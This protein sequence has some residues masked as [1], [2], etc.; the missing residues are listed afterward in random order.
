MVLVPLD[1]RQEMILHL[2]L[3]GTDPHIRRS[4][5]YSLTEPTAKRGRRCLSW[6]SSIDGLSF[7]SLP[8]DPGR[9]QRHGGRVPMVRRDPVGTGPL[10]TH[11]QLRAKHPGGGGI[12]RFHGEMA[13]FYWRRQ[14]H[15]TQSHLLSCRLAV[16]H[17]L[18]LP[19]HILNLS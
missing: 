1:C 12:R 15:E 11:Q 16:L 3:P 4:H 5:T 19:Q 6:H 14:I 7:P 9:A 2:E 10:Q 8:T 18:D 13:L 17:T